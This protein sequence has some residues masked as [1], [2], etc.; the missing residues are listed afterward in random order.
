MTHVITLPGTFAM[1]SRHGAA[2]AE[3][4]P[5]NHVIFCK[6]QP[7]APSGVRTE[8]HRRPLRQISSQRRIFLSFPERKSNSAFF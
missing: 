8:R 1:S 2:I 5:I 3:K 4:T 6:T 7:K